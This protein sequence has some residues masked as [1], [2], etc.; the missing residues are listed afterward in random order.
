VPLLAFLPSA[1][2]GTH[3]NVKNAWEIAC[4]AQTLEKNPSNLGIISARFFVEIHF[5]FKKILIKKLS[6]I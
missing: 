5:S 3:Q 6:N 2:A 4:A 1:F